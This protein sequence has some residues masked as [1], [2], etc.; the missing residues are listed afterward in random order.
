MSTYL[1]PQNQIDE[2]VIQQLSAAQIRMGSANT[3]RELVL[4][5]DDENMKV[6]AISTPLLMLVLNYPAEIFVSM[7]KV[8]LNVPGVS[9]IDW[10]NHA[11][12]L[13]SEDWITFLEVARK[14]GDLLPNVD[15][16]EAYSKSPEI[17]KHPATT[18]E[19][20]DDAE[21]GMFDEHFQ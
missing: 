18:P 14:S 16:A 2:N 9:Y 11:S 1:I 8:L 6:V 13:P 7:P 19:Q 3:I 5:T 4:E 17:E 12:K 10:L 15:A 21:E 20:Y